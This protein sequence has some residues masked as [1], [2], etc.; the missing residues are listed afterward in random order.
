MKDLRVTLAVDTLQ[1]RK[2]GLSS[3]PGYIRMAGPKLSTASEVRVNGVLSS[4]IIV[5]DD[6]TI[7]AALPDSS[8]KTP[9]R[10]I[11]VRSLNFTGRASAS[12]SFELSLEYQPVEGLDK[13]VQTFLCLLLSTPGSDAFHKEE[14]GGLRTSLSA[15]VNKNVRATY[16]TPVATAVE[17]TKQQLIWSQVSS[18]IP[19]NERLRDVQVQSISFIEA[20]GT[21]SI[22][23]GLQSMAGHAAA[24]AFGI[25]AAV[26]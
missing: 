26:S 2:V 22:E 5:V 19:L 10:E 16:A 7:D 25:N 21:V 8:F 14:G 9:V 24:A 3:I 23:L 20:T 11:E 12:I 17:R 13:L 18:K 6:S 4:D 15:G 1:V